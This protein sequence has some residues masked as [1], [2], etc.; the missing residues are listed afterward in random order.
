MTESKRYIYIYSTGEIEK[1]ID[2]DLLKYKDNITV[3]ELAK[4]I[5]YGK[6]YYVKKWTEYIP[7]KKLKKKGDIIV[8]REKYELFDEEEYYRD[9]E[10][11]VR[12]KYPHEINKLVKFFKNKIDKLND[13]VKELN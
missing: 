5:Y 9:R 7:D 13:K 1:C 6:L 4:F 12:L 8:S 11:D 3:D 10:D 2:I